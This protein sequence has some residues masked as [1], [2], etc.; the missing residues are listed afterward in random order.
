ML[1][2][3]KLRHGVRR[4]ALGHT[5]TKLTD[6][7]LAT[8]T[9]VMLGPLLAVH[10]PLYQARDTA[11][12]PALELLPRRSGCRGPHP[13]SLLLIPPSVGLNGSPDLELFSS[14]SLRLPSLFFSRGPCCSPKP[15]NQWPVFLVTNN[16]DNS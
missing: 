12:R 2:M 8:V 4:S 1:Q 3:K 6:G 7:T 16:N 13:P 15:E 10:H 14:L 11:L 9:E 5:A